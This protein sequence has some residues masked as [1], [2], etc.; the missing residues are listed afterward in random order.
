MDSILA[1]E[2]SYW[3][4]VYSGIL[5][6]SLLVVAV[7]CTLLIK[8]R[9]LRTEQDEK[10]DETGESG[11]NGTASNSVHKI[12]IKDKSDSF[13]NNETNLVINPQDSA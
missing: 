3:G 10:A 9:L 13:V 5:M 6:T 7:V 1:K 12:S 8:E 11:E 2:P 4:S